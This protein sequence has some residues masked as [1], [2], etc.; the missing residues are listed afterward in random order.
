[1]FNAS[2]LFFCKNKLK[3]YQHFECSYVF[4]NTLARIR[5]ALWQISIKFPDKLA[6]R[7]TSV[8]L[9]YKSVADNLVKILIKLFVMAVKIKNISKHKIPP[10]DSFNSSTE[11][12]IKTWWFW[13]CLNCKAN[14]FAIEE[15]S[16]N[17][18]TWH[19]MIWKCFEMIQQ[20]TQKWMVAV[21]ANN[22]AELDT[23]SIT[24]WVVD[25]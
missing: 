21:V 3:M 11:R 22:F 13:S 19:S 5:S 23:N 10:N 18:F 16:D 15:D 1:M 17:F 6:M 9:L 24:A 12:Q 7:T 14:R 8:I 2:S 20:L 4:L 25:E